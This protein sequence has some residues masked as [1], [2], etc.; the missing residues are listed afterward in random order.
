MRPRN[1]LV[2]DLLEQLERLGAHG[3]SLFDA[4]AGIE[5][6]EAYTRAQ[7][8]DDGVLVDVSAQ[9][10]ALGICFPFAVTACAWA[11]VIGF[12]FNAN[13][14]QE[15]ER[16]VKELI[17]RANKELSQ[18]TLRDVCFSISVEKS[19]GS[20]EVELRATFSR[21]DDGDPVYTVMLSYED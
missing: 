18:S 21:G 11:E 3:F 10:R 9:A 7:A 5:V 12:P 19:K 16:R 17:E 13:D 4:C 6:M 1:V 2:S 15:E 14:K 20:E 8:L